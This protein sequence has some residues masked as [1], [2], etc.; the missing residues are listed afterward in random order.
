MIAFLS[1]LFRRP[2]V[3]MPAWIEVVELQRRLGAGAAV[4]VLC[5]SPRNSSRLRATCPVPSTCHW[6]I[7]RAGLG[8]LPPGDSRSWWFGRPIADRPRQRRSYVPPAY[9]MSPSFVAEQTGGIDKVWRSNSWEM[10]NAPKS[11]GRYDVRTVTFDVPIRPPFAPS[12]E[13]AQSRP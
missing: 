7:C 9:R 1:R 11:R 5:V 6:V 4:V 12:P 2:R 10:G 13:V 3:A 8:N